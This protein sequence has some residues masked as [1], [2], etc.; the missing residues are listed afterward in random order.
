MY[1]GMA[2]RGGNTSCW[3]LMRVTVYECRGRVLL[4][5]RY[6]ERYSQKAAAGA[7]RSTV[8]R[9]DD[10]GV[11]QEA[12]EDTKSSRYQC[13]PFS[14]EVGGGGAAAPEASGRGGGR[15]DAVAAGLPAAGH[16]STGGMRSRGGK[17]AV[18]SSGALACFGE[19]K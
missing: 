11:T 14:I 1:A 4:Q 19:D 12:Q 16:T 3:L 7:G 9:V 17:R 18:G 5:V 10:A 15:G 8:V 2:R 13:G 6:L